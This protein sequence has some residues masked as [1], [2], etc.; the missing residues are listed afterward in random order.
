MKGKESSICQQEDV[1]EMEK[2]FKCYPKVHM[3][4]LALIICHVDDFMF[5]TETVF[6]RNDKKFEET[7]FW[8]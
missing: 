7:A 3:I 1:N 2:I 8:E 4:S 5:T 6:L